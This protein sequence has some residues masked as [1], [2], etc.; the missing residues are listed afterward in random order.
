MK[1]PKLPKLQPR[2]RLL[3]VGSG[4]VM[5]AVL[6]DR[7]VLS[8]WLHQS[9]TIRQETQR[10]EQGLQTHARL[11][12]RREGVLAAHE[13]YRRY[14][15]PAIPDDLQM[16]ALLKEIEDLALQSNVHIAEIK[17]SPVETTG[18]ATGY[19]LDVQFDCT[20]EEWV[21]FIYRIESSTSLYGV[22]RAGLAQQ[23]NEPSRLRGSLRLVS[24]TPQITPTGS[25]ADAG[26][27]HAATTQ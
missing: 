18:L 3:A 1:L 13:R 19:A 16:A 20:L 11:L 25:P 8:P 21:E 23:E 4:L 24:A 12:E 26:E 2:E 27:G 22:V 17:P 6:L 15:R 5:L 7:A 14:L 10:M 9:R